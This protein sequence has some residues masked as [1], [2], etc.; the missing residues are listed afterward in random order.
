RH[1]PEPC[2]PHSET[3]STGSGGERY[4]PYAQRTGAESVVYFS[5]DLSAE[6]LRRIYK[7][8]S[9]AMTGKVAVK[10]HTGEQHGPNIIPR[11]W[12]KNLLETELPDA[13]I[14]ETNTYYA[15][16]RYTTE[17]HRKTLEVNGW[18]FCPVDIL[19][20]TGTAMLPVKDGKWF[21]EMSV[22]AG[23]LNY[24]ALLV[25]THFKGHT[26]GGFGGSNKNI[27]I[28]CAD[29]R[30]GKAM[31][32]TTPGSTDMW[33][34]QKEEFM[35]RMTESAKSVVD[36]FGQNISFINVLRNMS[37]SCDC[38]GTAAMPVVT[39]NIGILASL[40]ILAVDQASVDLVYALKEA[41]H[42]ALVE[43][44]ESRHG[45]RQLSYMKEL[46]MGNDR[47]RLLD[48]DNDDAE[49]TLAEAVADVRP[50]QETE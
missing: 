34:I 4:V 10:L 24:D 26:N 11:P 45:L 46:H 16:D 50:F 17:Q 6:G 44:M 40:D 18:T 33:D 41:D 42:H 1:P 7:R 48:I 5:R 43:R 28:G 32:H 37:V 14:V 38:E 2:Q 12:V 22:G 35:E 3:P 20:E 30:V 36:H 9:S 47:Y 31:I 29:G 21:R 15:G 27:G 19:D 13:T 25:L 49:I 39:P 23:L 8:V